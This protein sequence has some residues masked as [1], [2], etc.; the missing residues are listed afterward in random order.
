M[1]DMK[2]AIYLLACFIVPAMAQAQPGTP[3]KEGFAWLQHTARGA[4][5]SAVAAEAGKADNKR[6]L[7]PGRYFIYLEHKNG[8][9]ILPFRIWIN[10][11]PYR[12]NNTTIDK[13]PVVRER[14]DLGTGSVYDTLVAARRNKLVQVEA[15]AP[16]KN[17]TIPHAAG[18][19]ATPH[20]DKIVVEY[21]WR[22]KTYAYTI[23]EI[24][25]LE[26]VRLQ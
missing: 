23:H 26:A 3:V 6:P 7:S 16:I 5:P 19:S 4:K 14:P 25:I 18:L 9:R 2:K 24:K 11:Q 20:P 17:L 8:Q 13:T 1:D 15:A 22:A 12:V 10:G 21:Y